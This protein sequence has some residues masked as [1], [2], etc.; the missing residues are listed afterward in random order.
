MKVYVREIILKTNSKY[1]L[2]DLTRDVEHI[3]SESNIRNGFCLVFAP[4]ATAAIIA[5]EHEYGLIQD[6]LRKVREEF[7]EDGK[8]KHNVIDDNA[9]AHLASAFIGADKMFPV[10]DGKLVRGTWQNIFLLEMDG[11]RSYRRIIVEVLG[12]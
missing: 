8:W 12:E 6:V 11:P 3:V 5:N 7:P 1:Q 4:H 10:I 2:I 9:H